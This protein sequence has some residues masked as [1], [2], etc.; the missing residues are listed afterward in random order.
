MNTPKERVIYPLEFPIEFRDYG[1]TSKLFRHE[2]LAQPP[3]EA[4]PKVPS[5]EWIMEVKRSSEAIRILS[6]SMT[7]PCS[8]RG[9]NIEAMHNPTVGTNIMLEFL[10]KSLLG[11]MPLVPM[12]KHFKSSLG[13]FFKCYGIAR[14]VPIIINET[15]VHLDFHIYAIL[16][17]DLLIGCPFE[18]LFMKNLLMGALM[19][20]LG[21][22]LLLLT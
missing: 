2:K 16:D 19:K 21:R 1:N 5:K 6:P 10:M 8:L 3:E 15:E 18:M 11:N 9:T 13:L 22:L 17:F 7:M 4:S 20:S 12:N 14:D